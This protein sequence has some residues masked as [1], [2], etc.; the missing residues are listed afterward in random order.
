MS[1]DDPPS[2]SKRP[3]R[4][5]RTDRA[6]SINNLKSIIEKNK[7]TIS[8]PI[9][10]NKVKLRLSEGSNGNT[11][12]INRRISF[13][14]TSTSTSTPTPTIS[15]TLDSSTN[16]G[17]LLLA[18]PFNLPPSS[19]NQFVSKQDQRENISVIVRCR[20]FI[21]NEGKVN[22]KRYIQYIF[23]CYIFIC[24]YVFIVARVKKV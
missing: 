3:V 6:Q 15:R 8:P 12:A 4:K 22:K 17:S 10:M 2:S 11:P 1:S 20:P 23:Y 7:N 18:R 16:I 9:G 14:S 5:P 21:G 13:Q 19:S 24:A